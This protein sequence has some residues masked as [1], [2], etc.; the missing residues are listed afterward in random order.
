M[1]GLPRRTAACRGLVRSIVRGFV[2]GTA[3]VALATLCLPAAQARGQ[4]EEPV[5]PGPCTFPAK[6]YAGRPWPLQRVPLDEVWAQSRGKNGSRGKNVRVAVVDTGV[7]TRNPQLTDAV[8]TRAGANFLPRKGAPA[9][10]GARGAGNGTSDEVGHGTKVAGLVAARPHPDTGF[11]G[12]APEATIIPIDQNDAE[13]NGTAE[14]LANAID[15]AVRQRADIINISQDTAKA[16]KPTRLLERAVEKALAA[17]TIVIAS[18]GNNGTDGNRDRTY[19]ASY[20]GVLAV[21]SSDRDNERAYFSQS[22]SFVGIAAPGTDIVSTVPGGGHCTDSGT[23][24]SAPYVAGLAALIKGAHD[25]WTGPQIVARIKQTAERSGPGPDPFVGWGVAD[26]LRALTRDAQ[27]I[28]HPVADGGPSRGQAPAPLAAPA[29]ETPQERS[30]RLSVYVLTG[31]A[32]ALAV[33]TG[34][35]VAVRDA[36][37]RGRRTAGE[38]TS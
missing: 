38:R 19:P 9:D 5:D 35:A 29:G 4:S 26:P 3:T 1:T 28:D 33:L 7:D 21:A 27:G 16:V 13:G 11:V 18:A 30:V 22:G 17:D 15:H 20:E 12:L 32:V 14:L 6:P 37:R 8:D 23:S 31:S 34:S 36:R 24:F 25:D 2:R 10:P